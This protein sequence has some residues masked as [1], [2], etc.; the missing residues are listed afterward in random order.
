MI[1]TSVVLVAA[2]VAPASPTGNPLV[3]TSAGGQLGDAL[4]ISTSYGMTGD[5]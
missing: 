2:I 5:G 1:V 3:T 4:A